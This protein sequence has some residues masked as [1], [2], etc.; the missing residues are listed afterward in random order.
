MYKCRFWLNS[1]KQSS[2]FINSLTRLT[3]LKN[4]PALYVSS[5]FFTHI[6]PEL[7]INPLPFFIYLPL[8]PLTPLTPLIPLTPLSVSSMLFVSCVY[9]MRLSP[10]SRLCCSSPASRLCC[11]SPASISCV[12]LLRLSHASISCVYLMRLSPASRL[13]CSSPASISCVYLVRLVCVV[14][15]CSYRPPYTPLNM[16]SV[17][18]PLSDLMRLCCSSCSSL[19]IRPP[20]QFKHSIHS[21]R[22]THITP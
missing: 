7:L 21:K 13:C 8:T 12:Y 15:C 16:L 22:L 4:S 20:K 3:L 10:A 19:L 1:L 5:H 14:V 6:T 17:L 18:T 2:H 9:L 11:S